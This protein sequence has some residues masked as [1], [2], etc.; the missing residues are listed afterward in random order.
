MNTRAHKSFSPS[1]VKVRLYS[2]PAAFIGL[3]LVKGALSVTPNSGIGV[4]RF[5]TI[6]Y[7]LLLLLGIV[8]AIR[9]AVGQHEGTRLFWAL[10]ACGYGFWALDQWLYLYYVIGLGTDVPDSSIADPALFLHV[11]PFMAALAMQPHLNRSNQRLSRASLNFFLL[12][13]FWVFLYAYFLFPHQYLWTSDKYGVRFDILYSIENITLVLAA[14]VATARA[15]GT[16]RSIYL[17]L[18]GAAALYALSSTLANFVIDT[19]RQY[20]GSVYSLAQTAAVCWFA[21]LPL[22]AS[23]LPST[24][25]TRSHCDASHTDL[26]SQLAMLA[27]LAIPLIGIW[28]EFRPDQH[29]GMHSFRL[30]V[31]LVSI[32][33]LA[34]CVFVKEHLTKRELVADVRVG[35]LQQQL[36][37]AAL[38]ESQ[39]LKGSILSSLENLI[40]VLDKAGNDH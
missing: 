40:A 36:S 35:N 32:V 39:V 1:E 10:M 33:L 14:A 31:V 5:G 28:E 24:E 21:W 8:F 25:V 2:W 3:L 16:W 29:P 38:S 4:V 23:Q 7:F 17:Q 11:V 6:V 22:R 12:L 13:F 27:V 26:T 18:L 34:A 37:E 20:N 9:N 15:K 30:A 19:G